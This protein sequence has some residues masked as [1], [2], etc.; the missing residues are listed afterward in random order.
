VRILDRL[1]REIDHDCWLLR[2][3]RLLPPQ[4]NPSDEGFVA[5]QDK[6]SRVRSP[7]LEGDHFLGGQEFINPISLAIVMPK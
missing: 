2:D 3:L 5:G 6:R 4:R 1:T 7:R